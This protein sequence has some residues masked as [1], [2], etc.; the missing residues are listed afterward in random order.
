[1]MYF[2]AHTHYPVNKVAAYGR[3]DRSSIRKGVVFFSSP[4]QS[5]I[6]WVSAALPRGIED[7]G[8]ARGSVVG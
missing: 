7:W 5:C 8:G 4:S 2:L 1:M 3:D 6:T